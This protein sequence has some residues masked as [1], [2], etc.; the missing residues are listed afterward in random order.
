MRSQTDHREGAVCV[1]DKEGYADS[2]GTGCTFN[3]REVCLDKR[4]RGAD[5]LLCLFDPKLDV[6]FRPREVISQ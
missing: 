1:S 6:Y 5:L 4:F 2:S 3:E